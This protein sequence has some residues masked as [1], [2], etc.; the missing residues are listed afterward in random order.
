MQCEQPSLTTELPSSH[1]WRT[2]QAEKVKFI[3]NTHTDKRFSVATDLCAIIVDNAVTAELERDKVLKKILIER[4]REAE[5]KRYFLCTYIN[6]ALCASI[7][8]STVAIVAFLEVWNHQIKIVELHYLFYFNS[9]KRE[10]DSP[11]CCCYS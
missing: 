1:S 7:Q 3:F 9:K 5:V 2:F 4:E 10:N 8:R 6:F 11:Q